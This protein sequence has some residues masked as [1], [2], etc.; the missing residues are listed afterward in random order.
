MFS[1]VGKVSLYPLLLDLRV[2]SATGTGPQGQPAKDSRG[3]EGKQPR[4][5]LTRSGHHL[6]LPARAIRTRR[7]K[8]SP[9]VRLHF[10]SIAETPGK[11]ARLEP[12]GTT[13]P[14]M[15]Y[16][17]DVVME[18]DFSYV[19]DSHQWARA[20]RCS[21]RICSMAVRYDTRCETT[22]PTAPRAS[23][24]MEL[25]AVDVEKRIRDCLENAGF[26]IH[27]FKV[28]QR[29]SEISIQV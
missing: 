11:K 10:R 21:C 5:L 4:P 6:A 9:R 1:H 7:C 20:R 12:A 25:R 24:V 26:E 28:P 19:T 29:C 27:P 15:H 18:R 13:F 23:S 17:P 14:S 3:E 8:P 2:H 22:F 16:I